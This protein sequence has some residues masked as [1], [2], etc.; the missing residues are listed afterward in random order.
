MKVEVKFDW[1]NPTNGNSLIDAVFD[2]IFDFTCYHINNSIYQC[3]QT[4]IVTHEFL[5]VYENSRRVCFVPE[6][7]ARKMEN[8]SFVAP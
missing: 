7:R 2:V 3:F 6:G 1:K 4:T 8:C 5:Q